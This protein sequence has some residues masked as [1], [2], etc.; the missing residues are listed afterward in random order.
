MNRTASES[1]G[2]NEQ[3][4]NLLA[5]PSERVDNGMSGEVQLSI[6]NPAS[7]AQVYWFQFLCANTIAN[8][9]IK[10]IADAYIRCEQ[11]CIEENTC[12]RHARLSS[13]GRQC[14][15]IEV[16]SFAWRAPWISSATIVFDCDINGVTG[17][18]FSFHLLGNARSTLTL[19]LNCEFIYLS[20][21][22]W[23][24]AIEVIF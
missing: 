12:S 23:R 11:L 21:L 19:F 9:M 16:H 22:P 3:N 10:L 17:I 5:P 13:S 15:S 7:N 18:R 14:I 8:E 6:T 2:S 4:K 20:T 1:E 24:R